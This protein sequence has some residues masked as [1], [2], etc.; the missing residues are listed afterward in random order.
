M[1]RVLPDID[2]DHGNRSCAVAGIVCSLSGRPLPASIAGGAGARPDHPISGCI[3]RPCVARRFRRVGGGRSCINVSGFC[4]ERWL[5]AIMDISARAISLSDRPRPGQSGH[6]CRR[7]REDRTS[8]SFILSQ[9][10][11]GSSQ[12]FMQTKRLTPWPASPRSFGLGLAAAPARLRS[13]LTAPGA[14]RR[15]WPR[16]PPRSRRGSRR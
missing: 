2:T 12:F 14:R 11:A 8:I 9:T 10:S 13:L 4:L 7:R 6:Q 3:V 16:S 1:E 5:L 15:G